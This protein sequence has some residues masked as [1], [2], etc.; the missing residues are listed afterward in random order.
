MA[1]NAPDTPP[2]T[3]WIIWIA[4]F[5]SVILY[6]AIGLYLPING[7]APA[8]DVAKLLTQVCGFVSL[9]NLGVVFGLQRVLAARLPYVVYSIVR[10]ALCESVAVFGLVLHFL[11]AQ[12]AV[13]LAFVAASAF[14][15]VLVRPSDGAKESF[16]EAKRAS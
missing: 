8:N 5:S 2:Q 1:I 4:L 9:T 16:E 10:W 3:L 6:A 13:L 12:D 14:A 11:G 15:M 7:D